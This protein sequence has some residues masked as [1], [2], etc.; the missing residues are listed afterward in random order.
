M[1][2][3]YTFKSVSNLEDIDKIVSLT[4]K[5][6]K[7]MWNFQIAEIQDV[8]VKHIMTGKWPLMTKQKLSL[9]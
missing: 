1:K 8:G 2:N 7:A 3:Y 4:A 5:A 6:N 9:L